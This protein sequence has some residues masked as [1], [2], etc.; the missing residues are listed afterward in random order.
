MTPAIRLL[1]DRQIPYDL[2]SYDAGALDPGQAG[3]G[4][5]AA[6]A[7]GLPPVAVFK[8][9]MAEID[10]NDP[11]I[12]V[13]PVA[14][15][16]DGK[17]LAAAG[18]GRRAALLTAQRSERLSG[19]VLGAISPLGQRRRLPTFIDR[20][21]L[22]WPRIYVSAGRR[23]LELGLAPEALVSLCDAVLVDLTAAS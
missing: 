19:Y 9:L 21:A 4:V 20:S 23:G 1:E 15:R 13:L 2:L 16:L 8:T 5:A 17:A 11:C 22:A 18:K 14:E 12:A 6:A 10:G 3:Y 7:L